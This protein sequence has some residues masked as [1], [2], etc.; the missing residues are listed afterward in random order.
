MPL[1]PLQI[2]PGELARKKLLLQLRE[3]RLRTGKL[4]SKLICFSIQKHDR[5]HLGRA[6]EFKFDH[7]QKRFF[8][9]N[10]KVIL[11]FGYEAD[12]LRAGRRRC[13]HLFGQTFHRHVVKPLRLLQLGPSYGR[14][15][16]LTGR[17]Q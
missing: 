4:E 16:G 8:P 5:A 6:V 17:R 9:L 10:Q 11:F 15:S 3:T 7:H 12:P 14:F 13:N 2:L 1:E